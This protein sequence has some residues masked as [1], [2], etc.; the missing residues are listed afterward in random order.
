MFQKATLARGQSLNLE[1]FNSKS[2]AK[3]EEASQDRPTDAVRTCANNSF[4]EVN[5]NNINAQESQVA[6]SN[7]IKVKQQSNHEFQCNCLIYI[8]ALNL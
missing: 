7:F 2:L 4:S 1:P 5:V 6:D 3:D 8:H